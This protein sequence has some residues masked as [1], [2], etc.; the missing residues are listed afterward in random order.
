[1]PSSVGIP[2]VPKSWGVP[3]RSLS[4]VVFY[5]KVFHFA[6]LILMIISEKRCNKLPALIEIEAKRTVEV[7]GKI[8]SG[9]F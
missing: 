5:F 4:F 1:M 7:L 2:R 6:F 9:L 8:K 3:G